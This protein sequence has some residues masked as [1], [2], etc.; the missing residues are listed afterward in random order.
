MTWQNTPSY[1]VIL[2]FCAAG[3]EGGMLKYCEHGDTIQRMRRVANI[4]PCRDWR[5]DKLTML[6]GYLLGY[7]G[8]NE[9]AV[10]Y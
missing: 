9:D 2:C 8:F 5:Y 1:L 7:A 3:R 6:I 10:L 4:V